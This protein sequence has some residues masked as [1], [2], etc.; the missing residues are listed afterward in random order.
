MASRTYNF[1]LAKAKALL[2]AGDG[3]FDYAKTVRWLSWNKDARDRQSFIE[4]C[5]SEDEDDRRQDRDHQ[6]ARRHGRARARP[7]TGTCS[8]TV[9]IPIQEPDQIRT[10]H[11]LR[12]HSAA[13]KL[14]EWLYMRAAPTSSN[15]CNPEFDD[16]M[17]Q[18]SRIADQ[19]ERAA[20]YKQAQ[21]ICLEQVPIMVTYSNAQRVCVERQAHR[22]GPSTA[23]RRR[24]SGRSTKWSKTP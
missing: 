15:F 22:R 1:D 14:A 23:I 6:R 10:V 21:D 20:L 18:A 4:D 17:A 13:N 3:K 19:A 8:S 5:Q 2:D 24:C 16:L 7:A 12:G 9:A 11:R